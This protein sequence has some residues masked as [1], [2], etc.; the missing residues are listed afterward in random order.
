MNTPKVLYQFPQCAGQ[1]FRPSNGTCGEIFHEAFCYQCIHER[2]VH[3]MSE[4]RDE[5]KCE[6]WSR[7][8]AYEK[9]DPRY[10]TEWI[11]NSEGWPVC[12]SWKKFDWGTHDDP[13]EPDQPITPEPEDPRQLMMP[14]DITELFPCEEVAVFKTGI[15]ETAWLKELQEA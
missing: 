15:V 13:N 6:I 12:T 8:M 4:D 10:P 2:W 9:D 11:Y 7:V 1:R 3:R 14:F 5:D